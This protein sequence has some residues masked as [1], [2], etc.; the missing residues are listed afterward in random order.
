MTYG[1]RSGELMWLLSSI[2]FLGACLNKIGLPLCEIKTWFEV[3]NGNSN[4]G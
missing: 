4:A 2:A 1:G 3:S